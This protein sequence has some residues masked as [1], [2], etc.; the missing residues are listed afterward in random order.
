MWNSAGMLG[1]GT[2]RKTSDCEVE[3]PPKKMDGAALAA[4]TRTEFF[5]DAIALQQHAPE[6]IGVFRI[7]GTMLLILLK[8][9]RGINFVRRSVDR[10]IQI[11]LTQSSHYLAIE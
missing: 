7:V 6:T 8:R 10:C 11:Q 9:D 2:S 3:A 1:R 5:E 4:E